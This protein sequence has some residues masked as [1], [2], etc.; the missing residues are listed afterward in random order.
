MGMTS[1]ARTFFDEST[2]VLK[3]VLDGLYYMVYPVLNTL[4]LTPYALRLTP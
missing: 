4:R 3:N 1:S 2:A